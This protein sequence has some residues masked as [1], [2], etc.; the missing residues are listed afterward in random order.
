MVCAQPRISPGEWDAQIPLRF[1]DTY[2]S[3]NLGQTTRTYNNQQQQK[4]EVSDLWT[5]LSRLTIEQNWKKAERKIYTW[6]LLENWKKTMDHESD[7]DSNCHW[8]SWYSHQRICTG[9]GGLENKRTSETIQTTPLL[10][11]VRILRRVLKTWGDLLSL[12]P[13]WETIV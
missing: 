10:R 2:G 6:T 12:N 1:W 5:L 3:P 4:R 7:G 13:Q 9:T 11:S 8:F